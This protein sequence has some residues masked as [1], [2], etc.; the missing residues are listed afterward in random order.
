MSDVQLARR[1][2]LWLLLAAYL[3]LRLLAVC[4]AAS[5]DDHLEAA[6]QGAPVDCED[7]GTWYAAQYLQAPT[8][9]PLC[10]R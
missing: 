2:S 7:I 1:R 8:L 6:R 9:V 10:G 5:Q 3:A 4:Q